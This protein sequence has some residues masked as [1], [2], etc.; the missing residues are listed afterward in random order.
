M[1]RNFNNFFLAIV[2]DENLR[3][4]NVTI[5]WKDREEKAVTLRNL[6]IFLAVADCGSMSE[7]AKKM[8]I[9]QPSVSGT[10][11]EIEEQYQVRLFERLGRRLY[12]TPT[13]EQLCEYARHIL[14]TFDNMEQRLHNADNTD[15]LRI[16]ATVTVGTCILGDVLNQYIGE[17]G[18]PAPRI[19]VD[20]TQVIEQQLLKSELDTAIVEGKISSP[21]LVT[22]FMMNDP[23][24]LVCAADHNPFGER[25]CVSMAELRNI[26]FILRE[27]G[28]GTREVFESAMP[29]INAQWVCNNSEAILH[30]VEQGFGMTVISRRLAERRL[31]SGALLE[32]HVTDM[33]LEREFSV[34]W[35]KNKYKS[36]SLQQFIDTSIRYG[37]Q[38]ERS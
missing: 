35:H 24:A 33:S 5:N 2:Q 13:G 12:I 37:L 6:R 4:N 21:D 31:E 26:P 28:S 16:G 27:K 38:L 10:I 22:Q 30:G 15:M 14:S 29:N 11:S 32:L 20:N 19:L 25:R 3:Y 23:L 9:A 7:A 34:V 18:N 8:H 36:T 17:T 1:N